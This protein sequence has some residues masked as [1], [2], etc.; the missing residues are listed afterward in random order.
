MKGIE[1]QSGFQATEQAAKDIEMVTLCLRALSNILDF[2]F[3]EEVSRGEIACLAGYLS[4]CH[5]SG[6]PADIMSAI[7]EYYYQTRQ[8]RSRI[9]RIFSTN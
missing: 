8:P 7:R 4:E 9:G 5:K 2:E 6:R 1:E 3:D